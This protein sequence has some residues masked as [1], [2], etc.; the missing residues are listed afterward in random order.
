[1]KI[2]LVTD[3]G[4]V[5]DRGFNEF[6]IKGLDKAK[7]DLDIETR[8]YVSNSADDYE[9]NLEAAVDD[10]ERSRGCRRVPACAVG[11]QGC[12][13]EPRRLVRGRRP[14]LRPAGSDDGCEESKTCASTTPSA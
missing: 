3:T 10:G 6:S 14:F 11:D 4:G 2:G 5:D 8:V 7:A 9:P 13:G 12:D 1:M